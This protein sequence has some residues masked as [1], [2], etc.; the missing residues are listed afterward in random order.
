MIQICWSY[1]TLGVKRGAI[2]NSST[3][4]DPLLTPGMSHEITPFWKNGGW[5]GVGRG[6]MVEAL[7]INIKCATPG[8]FPMMH[9]SLLSTVTWD[10]VAEAAAEV[11]LSQT[12]SVMATSRHGKGSKKNGQPQCR[13]IVDSNTP[14]L[15][16][17][18]TRELT[19]KSL[20]TTVSSLQMPCHVD[21]NRAFH[22]SV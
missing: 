7:K 6:V 12:I 8:A 4:A 11:Y 15:A 17:P 1:C 19:A 20:H 10:T 18:Q 16:R 14:T 2:C 9:C 5:D 21:V 13:P 22:T 3:P